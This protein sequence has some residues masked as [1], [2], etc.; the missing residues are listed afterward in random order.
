MLCAPNLMPRPSPRPPPRTRVT[1]VCWITS[2]SCPPRH[3]EAH[4][5]MNLFITLILEDIG[6]H[7]LSWERSIPSSFM[8][9]NYLF[10]FFIFRR[11]TYLLILYIYNMII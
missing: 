9:A 11:C 7:H 4:N 1:R 2:K 5:P 8:G 3:A 6:Y 10:I